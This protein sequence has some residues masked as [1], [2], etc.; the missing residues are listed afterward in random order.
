LSDVPGLIYDHKRNIKIE[1]DIVDTAGQTK[2]GQIVLTTKKSFYGINSLGFRDHKYGLD[3]LKGKEV[4]LC[5]GDS[6]TFGT[7]VRYEDTYPKALERR[8]IAEGKKNILVANAGVWGYDAWQYRAY[9]EHLGPELRP[10]TVVVG[11]FMNDH[12]R[13][14]PNTQKIGFLLEEKLVLANE[15]KNLWTAVSRRWS[16][17][18]VSAFRKELTLTHSS[19][20]INALEK[21]IEAFGGE[22]SLLASE[23]KRISNLPLWEKALKNIVEMKN[24]CDKRGIRFLVVIFPVRPQVMFEYEETEPQ[25]SIAGRLK[26]NGIAYRDMTNQFRNEITKGRLLYNSRN[27]GAHFNARAHALVAKT[28][29]E[30]LYK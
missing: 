15:L 25:Q 10:S 20:S 18:T 11:L 28:I 13:N 7:G 9:L 12:I 1:A 26:Q 27:D 22:Y 23:M 8:W 17:L 16:R 3:D 5:L 14:S 19:T 29:A 4:I 21:Q 6:T 30:A 24:Y 2:N